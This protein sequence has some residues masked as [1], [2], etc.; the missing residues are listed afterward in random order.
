MSPKVPNDGKTYFAVSDIHSFYDPLK[1]ALDEAGYDPSN[2]NHVLIV[3]GD[4]FDRGNQTLEV[5]DFL[6]S[7]PK[8]RRILIRGNHERLLRYCYL[9]GEYQSYDFSNGTVRTMCQLAGT[10]PDWREKYYQEMIFDTKLDDDQKS[11][12]Y[13]EEWERNYEKPF[14]SRKIKKVI[15]WM[16][17]DEWRDFYEVG[18]YIFVH[19]WL[20]LKKVLD[21]YGDERMTFDPD[22]RQAGESEWDEASWA[23]P[24]KMYQSGYL[25][26]GKTV[27]CG[28]WHTWDFHTHLGHDVDGYRN[29]DIYYSEHLIALDACT[30]L[31]PNICNVLI[32][33]G[34]RCYD[35]HHKA[36]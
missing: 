5:L 35:K 23:C 34:G 26:K 3:C 9:E 2:E 33:E 8:K 29:R 22:W 27:V 17:S 1:E 11:K 20:P 15:D 36:L 10:D 13:L 30:A 31:E 14:R 4:V 16:W 18:D 6:K 21:D 7:I 19:A 28:H 32:L 24:W 12:L 25:P